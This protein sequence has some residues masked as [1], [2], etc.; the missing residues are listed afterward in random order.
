MDVEI[1]LS[2]DEWEILPDHQQAQEWIGLIK[3]AAPGLGV[4]KESIALLDKFSHAL[5]KSKLQKA[6]QASSLHAFFPTKPRKKSDQDQ[7]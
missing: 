6:S 2:D 7:G 4:P 3:Q 1:N 5:R